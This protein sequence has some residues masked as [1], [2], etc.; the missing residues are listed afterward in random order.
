MQKLLNNTVLAIFK[1][2]HWN[3]HIIEGVPKKIKRKGKWNGISRWNSKVETWQFFESCITSTLLIIRK[4]A[5]FGVFFSVQ[6]TKFILK[7]VQKLQFLCQQSLRLLHQHH[8]LKFFRV[9]PD[10]ANLSKN[11]Q[12]SKFRVYF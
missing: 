1:W 5:S 12:L 10:L 2:M 8:N 11:L 4:I 7:Y 3:W 9:R 6:N